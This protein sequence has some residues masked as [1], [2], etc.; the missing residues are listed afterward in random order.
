MKEQT[1]N[2][3][4]NL[5]ENN[6]N[7]ASKVARGTMAA[8]WCYMNTIDYNS[9][10]LECRDMP[11]ERDISDFVNTLREAGVE[12]F[13]ITEKSTSL[14]ENLH[15]LA[16]LGCTIDCLCTVNRKRAYGEEEVPAIRIKI[17]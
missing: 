5:R 9:S 6:E 7:D 8:Y 13:A 11:W 1:R 17:N 2:Y 3:F 15:A 4:E 16:E 10:E 14:L 12:T